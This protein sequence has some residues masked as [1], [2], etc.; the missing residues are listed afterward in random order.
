MGEETTGALRAPHSPGCGRVEFAALAALAYDRP[1][2]HDRDDETLV[3]GG[4][5][6]GLTAA[7]HLAERGQR[8]LL[9]EAAARVGG[10]VAGGEPTTFEQA[11]RQWTFHGEH[12]LHGIW[13]GYHTL[14]GM[15]GRHGLL[16][17]LR[18]AQQEEWIL[19]TA[20][21]VRRAEVG[22]KIRGSLL[23]APLHYLILFGYPQF[24]M[25]L[26]PRDW[27]ALPLVWERL[28]IAVGVDPFGEEQPLRGQTLADFTRGWSP[29]LRNFFAGLARS[30]LSAHPDE[31]PLSGFIAFLRF[32]TVLRRDAWAFNYM[33]SDAG[34]AFV[35]PL[36][37]RIGELGGRVVTGATV[38][39]LARAG[40]GWEA[41]W[42]REGI[43][44]RATA[45]HL[46]VALDAPNARRLLTESPATAAE[47]TRLDWPRGMPTAIFRLWFDRTPRAGPEA[48]IFSGAFTIDNFF[49][50]HRLQDDYQAWHAATGGAA[51][52]SHIYG[53]PEVLSRPDAALA[54]EVIGDVQRAWPEL[55]GTLRHWTMQRNPA[56][57]TLLRAGTA[58]DLLG[59]ETP[60]PGLF[61]CGDWVRHPTPA[62]Y[63]ERATVTGVAAANAVLQAAGLAPFPLPAAP[64]PEPLAGWIE[65]LLRAGR[66]RLRRHRGD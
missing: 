13:S 34:R 5:L 29:A 36:A 64:A 21:G 3:I 15:L 50:L 14:A 25:M 37:A 46:I 9:L 6:A 26:S 30:A 49:W 38:T 41:A 17:P 22:S 66:R 18:P 20:A 42:V 33:R 23:P 59:T 10:R 24:L 16:P 19:G 8:V 43:S 32:Y 7:L 60:W 45:P 54:A 63:L 27:L 4:G 65:R 62:L 40:A 52:E 44:H 53:P 31:V 28:L 2:Q 51:V 47:A 35:E 48:G 61:A 55:R 56:T 39:G 11:G 12:G 1:M 58:T 57:H